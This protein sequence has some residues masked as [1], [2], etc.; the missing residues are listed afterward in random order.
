[1]E[2]QEMRMGRVG[3]GPRLRSQHST[4]SSDASNDPGRPMITIH[5]AHFDAMSAV[6]DPTMAEFGFGD[7]V[8]GSENSLRY[9]SSKIGDGNPEAT[10]QGAVDKMVME[11]LRQAEEAREGSVSVKKPPT[12]DSGAVSSR[13][14]SQSGKS[15]PQGASQLIEELKDL[16]IQQSSSKDS[17]NV[18]KHS[19]HGGKTSKKKKPQQQSSFRSRSNQRSLHS[20]SQESAASSYENGTQDPGSMHSFYSGSEVSSREA[21]M[22]SFYSGSEATSHD[23]GEFNC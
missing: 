4:R 21:G 14:I 11:A 6:S 7:S 9:S 19:Q 12:V 13:Q 1:M 17:V 22:Q 3:P 20:S 18:S 15:Q 2:T 16:A 8:L 5:N 10:R 23:V